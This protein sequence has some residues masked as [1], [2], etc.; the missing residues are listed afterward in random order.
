MKTYD[1]P[2]TI[3]STPGRHWL[4]AA[5]SIWRF[6]GR[7][8]GLWRLV[9]Y[10]SAIYRSW[11]KCPTIGPD[12][13][14]F[15]IDLRYGQF[16]WLVSGWH[17]AVIDSALAGLPEDAVA[18]D[19]G[20]HIGTMSR[21]FASRFASGH[22][23]A[24]EASPDNYR[25]LASNCAS[26][27]NITC[28]QMALGRNTGEESFSSGVTAPV[29]RRIVPKGPNTIS[30]PAMRLSDW[31]AQSK[32]RRLDF[33]KVD[34]EGFEEDV[35]VPARE[36]LKVFRPLIV[37]EFIA[38]FAKERS[39]Y[40]GERLFPLLESLNYLVYRLDQCGGR[41]SNFDE[42][43]VQMTNDYIATPRV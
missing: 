27:T 36:T 18:L 14:P 32:L 38:R 11:R 7:G 21:L 4:N 20:A 34:V 29:L 2:V 10:G 5:V 41:H 8:W 31:I 37:F 35:L 15:W 30:V 16:S 19:I 33:I 22:V 39:F 43:S 1:K 17:T 9:H 3:L 26:V 25:Q 28:S 40:R 6:C 12:L 24:F 13:R 42:V 23:Y